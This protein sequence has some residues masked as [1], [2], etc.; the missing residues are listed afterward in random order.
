MCL[1]LW[2]LDYNDF[3]YYVTLYDQKDIKKSKHTINMKSTRYSIFSEVSAKEFVHQ[4]DTNIFYPSL[5]YTDNIS[6]L[7][8]WW[9]LFD[10][11]KENKDDI[12]TILK[13]KYWIWLGLKWSKN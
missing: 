6:Y 9:K 5:F 4:D 11:L 8:I 2:I 13:D 12:K 3:A 1:E 7:F 10:I